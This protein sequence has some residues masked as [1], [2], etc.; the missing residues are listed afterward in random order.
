MRRPLGY[1]PTLRELHF[2][3]DVSRGGYRGRHRPGWALTLRRGLRAL[4]LFKNR[5]CSLLLNGVREL[6][7]ALGRLRATAKS[8]APRLVA[9]PMPVLDLNHLHIQFGSYRGTRRA[10]SPL[11]RAVRH[12]GQLRNGA[13]ESVPSRDTGAHRLE[14]LERLDNPAYLAAMR[15]RITYVLG[16]LGEFHA[17]ARGPRAHGEPSWRERLRASRRHEYATA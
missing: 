2:T 5:I 15:A 4:E 13:R 16:T 14:N 12:L 7:G 17:L 11:R 6:S 8:P 10:P 3:P 1:I 9:E